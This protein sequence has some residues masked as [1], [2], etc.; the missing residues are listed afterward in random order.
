MV[1]SGGTVQ[2]KDNDLQENDIDLG[3]QMA[4]LP[5]VKLNINEIEES[6][7]NYNKKG[8]FDFNVAPVEHNP[9]K[10]IKKK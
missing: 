4:D 6:A 2:V 7:N 1:R 3:I 8:N 10:V 9:H 5:P